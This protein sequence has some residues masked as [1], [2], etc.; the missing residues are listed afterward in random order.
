MTNK[1][2]VLSDNVAP[3]IGWSGI[4]DGMGVRV[5]GLAGRRL[6][7]ELEFWNVS[8]SEIKTSKAHSI[9]KW[10]SK[11]GKSEPMGLQMRSKPECYR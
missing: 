9:R 1:S 11:N 2:R 7:N 4:T 5:C 10:K 3:G 8:S 6:M